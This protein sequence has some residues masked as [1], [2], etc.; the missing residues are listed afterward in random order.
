METRN[1]WK[2][3]EDRKR[4]LQSMNL[5]P[6]EYEYKLG[7]MLNELEGREGRKKQNGPGE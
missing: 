4:Q 3:Y 2:V 1:L 5:T 6:E 7:E